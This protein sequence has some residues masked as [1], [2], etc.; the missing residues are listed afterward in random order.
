MS[1]NR[2]RNGSC[3]V[4]T[5]RLKVA[6]Q[7][8]PRENRVCRRNLG[9]KENEEKTGRKAHTSLGSKREY[10]GASSM[11]LAYIHLLLLRFLPAF[12]LSLSPCPFSC[13]PRIAHLFYL[14]DELPHDLTCTK[15][16]LNA[17]ESHAERYFEGSQPGSS[18]LL[19]ELV[20]AGESK[21]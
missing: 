5:A 12:P 9:R 21:R 17:C 8:C 19:G 18:G 2:R 14:P 10:I 4:S 7:G 13:S 15:V 20:A 3:R 11:Q 1:R 6:E 16:L